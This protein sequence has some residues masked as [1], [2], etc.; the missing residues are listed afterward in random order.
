MLPVADM[1]WGDGGGPELIT[2]IAGPITILPLRALQ[3]DSGGRHLRQW[4]W[5]MKNATFKTGMGFRGYRK[6]DV[7]YDL[8]L[9]LP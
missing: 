1:W 3:A 5:N 6:R 2:E 7:F 9:F 4:L 8:R